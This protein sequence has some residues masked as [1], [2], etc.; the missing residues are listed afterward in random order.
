MNSIGKILQ[1]TTFGESHGPALGGILDGFP[2]SVVIDQEF[3]QSE[4]DR[5]RPGQSAVTTGRKEPD[6]V[7]FLSVILIAFMTQAFALMTSLSS[8]SSS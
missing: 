2:P 3:I 8:V 1:L 4:L 5:R 7:E 6:K